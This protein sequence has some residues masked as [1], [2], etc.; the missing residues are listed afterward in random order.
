L[1]PPQVPY[2]G[3]HIGGVVL[4]LGVNPPP[5]FCLG[6]KWPCKVIGDGR[7]FEPT[8]LRVWGKKKLSIPPRPWSIV[9][10]L[11]PKMGQ[12]GRL[13]MQRKMT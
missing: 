6:F 11:R 2:R 1:T 5:K 4:V 3:V 7:K 13:Y 12:K 9:P 10:K 8:T